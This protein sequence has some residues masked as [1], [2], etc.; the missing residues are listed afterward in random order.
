MS[1]RACEQVN[2]R[3]SEFTQSTSRF[4]T[5]MGLMLF[6]QYT[7]A[8]MCVN[9]WVCVYVYVTAFAPMYVSIRMH[10]HHLSMCYLT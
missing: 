7:F 10:F 8:C 9:V 6:N 5:E 3:V 1:K 2:E 4:N